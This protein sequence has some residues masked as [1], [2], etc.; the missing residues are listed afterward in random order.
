LK[1]ITT[2]VI[3]AEQALKVDQKVMDQLKALELARSAE[4][5]VT[6]VT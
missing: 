5:E 2:L 6:E 1:Q 3:P 4:K